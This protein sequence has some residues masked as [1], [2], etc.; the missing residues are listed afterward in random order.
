MTSRK[1]G[2]RKNMQ[3]ANYKYVKAL[4][5]RCKDMSDA[6]PKISW[7]HPPSPSL[8][9]TMFHKKRSIQDTR[10]TPNAMMNLFGLTA[11]TDASWDLAHM[12]LEEQL[13]SG[14]LHSESFGPHES[15][16][17]YAPN[18]KTTRKTWSADAA[19]MFATRFFRPKI[20]FLSVDRDEFS[21][22]SATTINIKRDNNHL[23]PLPMF[24]L[25]VYME[26]PEK[27]TY[28]FTKGTS[29]TEKDE[30]IGQ[31]HCI[32]IDLR[33]ERMCILDDMQEGP[34]E[35]TEENLK[36][37]FQFGIFSV[38]QV[39]SLTNIRRHKRKRAIVV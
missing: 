3:E 28:H 5:A 12:L 11:V 23:N 25:E 1:K 9:V 4:Q 31:L 8:D 30:K 32:S 18:L 2:K 34:L 38:Y 20:Q 19:R 35:Y 13:L 21:F 37:S 10:C 36:Q 33:E 15:I 39:A 7:Q 22:E 16:S 17:T 29:F 26:P 24:I 6:H 14:V 27:R